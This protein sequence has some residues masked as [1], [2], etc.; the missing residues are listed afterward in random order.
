MDQ[1]SLSKLTNTSPAEIV[2]GFDGFIDSII[3][4]V[5]K[6]NSPE[7]FQP[8]STI[9]EFSGAVDSVA[10]K[11]ANFELVTQQTKMGGNGPL[12]ADTLARFDNNIHYIGSLGYPEIEDEFRNFTDRCSS[13]YTLAP[14]ARTDALEFDDGKLLLGKME[15]LKDVNREN[16]L[17]SIPQE[18]MRKMFDK[19]RM[20]IFN[21]WTMLPAM[22]EIMKLFSEMTENLSDKP[23]VFVDLADPSKRKEDDIIE[24][25]NILENME[26]DVKVIF[27]MNK[28]ESEIIA[29]VLEISEED[30]GQRA[31]RLQEKTGFHCIVIH[32]LEGAMAA[33]AAASGPLWVDGPYTDKPV[34]TTGAGDNFNAGFAHGWLAGLDIADALKAGVFTSGFYVR[35]AFAPD[36]VRLVDFIKQYKSHSIS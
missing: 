6:R 1:I 22:N 24:V 26:D 8:Y 25:L 29:E 33:S 15:T 10:G 7:D 13:V 16:I 36:I 31:V 2:A 19:A 17:R 9:T 34:L 21:N 11:S 20:V 5:K 23:A 14:A 32:P 28:R 18:D 12:M 4:V 35:N 27:S 3:K 30:L